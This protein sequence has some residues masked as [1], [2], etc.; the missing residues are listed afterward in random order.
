MESRSLQSE[1]SVESSMCTK[2]YPNTTGSLRSTQPPWQRSEPECEEDLQL[3]YLDVTKPSLMSPSVGAIAGDCS[4]Y[5]S[6]SQDWKCMPVYVSDREISS[7]AAPD[8]NGSSSDSDGQPVRRGFSTED[9]VEGSSD[10]DVPAST[11]SDHPRSSEAPSLAV[12]NSDDDSDHPRS[13]EAPSLAVQSLDHFHSSSDEGSGLSDEEPRAA[14]TMKSKDSQCWHPLLVIGWTGDLPLNESSNATPTCGAQPLSPPPLPPKPPS[15][16]SAGKFAET[17]KGL[18]KA[19]NTELR[20]LEE[21][22]RDLVASNSDDDRDHPCSPEVPSL[23]VQ[24]LDQFHSSF[25]EG[26]G[27]FDE[28]PRAARTMKSEDSQCCHPLVVVD[29]T[30]DLPLNESSNA[31]PTLP[32]LPPKPR[33]LFSAGKFAETAK[34]LSKALDTE[35]RDLEDEMRDLTEDLMAIKR[36][37]PSMSVDGELVFS[38]EP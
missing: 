11:D 37:I 18:S 27:L 9:S 26:V 22:M 38:M 16:F 35:L 6:P 12:P 2:S 1:C 13:P 29:R 25:D 15:L 20:D 34:G 4:V 31:T 7:T 32:P 36:T 33:S 19:L 28:E 10:S 21:E 14:R 3:E 30:V 5:T 17:P 24:S 23:A 8:S